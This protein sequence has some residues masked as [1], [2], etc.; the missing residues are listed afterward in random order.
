MSQLTDAQL[1]AEIA[2]CEFCECKPC[3]D[4]CPAHCSPADFI[5]AVRKGQPADFQ[6]SA[7]LILGK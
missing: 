3:R 6:R 7:A 1:Q 5:M 2:R 4:A